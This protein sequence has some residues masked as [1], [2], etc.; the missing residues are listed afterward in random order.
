MVYVVVQREWSDDTRGFVKIGRYQVAT[1]AWTFVPYPLDAVESPAGGRVGLSE[2]TALS[3]GT[4]AIVERDNQ[5]GLEARVKRIYGIDPADAGWR[6]HGEELDVIDKTLRRDILGDL[7]DASISVPDKV[8]GLGLTA[9]GEVWLSTDNDG[10]DETYAS[11]LQVV[12]DSVHVFVNFTGDDGD[13]VLNA[14]LVRGEAEQLGRADLEFSVWPVLIVYLAHLILV[15]CRRPRR[16]LESL[17]DY[18]ARR[19]LALEF[20]HV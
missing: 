8:E 4:L 15:E 19:L 20:E 16:V 12:D 9:D 1:E 6:A 18:V 11:C 2:S 17:S 10:V 14:N 3:D 7:D 5:L 13:L